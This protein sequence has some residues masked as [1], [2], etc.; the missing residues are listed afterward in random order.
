MSATEPTPRARTRALARDRQLPAARALA[1]AHALREDRE[2]PAARA[3][4]APRALPGAHELPA[5]ALATPRAHSLLPARPVFGVRVLPGSHSLVRVRTR[6]TTYPLLGRHPVHR[7]GPLLRG[8][9][10]LPSRV[11]VASRIARG[12]GGAVGTGAAVRTGGGAGGGGRGTG[13]ADANGMPPS[14]M[15]LRDLLNESVAGLFARPLR[16]VLTVLGTVIGLAALV[17]TM[18]LS[19]TAGNQIISRFDE[20]AAT[21]I[22]VSSQPAEEGA[23]PNTIPWN[24]PERV[25]RLNGVVAAGNLSSVDV[26]QALVRATPISDP[27]RRTQFKLAVE[28]ASPD[29]FPAVRAT[30]R[31]GRLPD[32]G[33]G[34]RRDRVAVLGP[35]AAKELGITD[36]SQQP[37]I[38]IGDDVFLVIG[39]LDG[40]KRKFGLLSAVILPEGTAQG[41]YRLTA[42]ESVVVETKVGAASLLSRQIPHALRP[43]VPA[44]LKIASPEQ[45]QQARAGVSS[46]LDALFLML[47]GVSLLVGAIGIANVTLVS[48]MER[49]GEIGLRRALGATRG[50]IAGQFLLESSAMGVVGGVLGAS[51][52]MLVVVGVA[53]YNSWTPVVDPTAPLLAPLLGG[54]TGLLAGC[55]P[56]LRAARLEPVE[57]LRSGT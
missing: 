15:W 30:L 48:V 16:M 20:L 27:Q 57:A 4:A 38:S 6:P 35:N 52:G 56:A 8:R 19:R 54:L 33:H 1:T 13:R 36:V 39:I 26:G 28:A 46:D 22:T 2:L 42:P 3:L 44:G 31:T 5:R 37:A 49:T 21:E 34:K 23:P 11:L 18:G 41:V 50:H 47:S 10:P 32:E 25:R 14:G 7:G 51:I 40:V 53:A 55:Y 12:A 9:T 29:L 24:A 45:P 43:D 17:A